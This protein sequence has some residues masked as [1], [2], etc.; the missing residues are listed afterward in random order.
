MKSISRAITNVFVSLFALA[1]PLQGS[2]TVVHTVDVPVTTKAGRWTHQVDEAGDYQIGVAWIEVKSRGQVDLRVLAGGKEIKSAIARPGPAPLRFETR[3][4]GLSPGDTIEVV[5]IPATGTRYRIGYQVAFCTPTFTGAKVFHVADYGAQGG[6]N[7]DDMAAIT[8]AVAAAKH[9][10]RGRVRFDGSKTYRVIGRADLTV[11]PVFDLDE[12]RNIKIE[13]NGATLM[14]HP[15]DRMAYIAFAENIDIDG[16]TVDYDPK[17]Y[18]QG[19]ITDIDVNNLTIDID[20]PQRYPVPEVGIA[21]T[22]APFFGRSFIPDTPAARSGRGENIYIASTSRHGSDRRIRIQV[23][24]TANGAS[25]APRVKDAHDNNAAEFVV[26]HIVYGHLGGNNVITRSS[27]AKLSNIRYYCAPY[28]WM[29]IISNTGPVT[30]SN[31]DMQTP[32]PE[33]ELYVTCLGGKSHGSRPIAKAYRNIGPKTAEFD[34]GFFFNGGSQL[35]TMA[36]GILQ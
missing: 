25:M 13:G 33:T 18:Y 29:S 9:A 26:P 12:A 21:P 11:E 35:I 17:P 15:P 24:K 2:T 19:T 6:G 28:F 4:E 22:H 5:A 20:V 30:L 3:V 14:I 32:H 23:P 31:V 27:R 8:R 7:T 34:D 36:K 1:I 16:F 10:G